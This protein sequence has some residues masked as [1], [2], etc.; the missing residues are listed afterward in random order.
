MIGELPDTDQL[1]GAVM[2][3]ATVASR[4]Q[5]HPAEVLKHLFKQHEGNW[6]SWWVGGNVDRSIPQMSCSTHSLLPAR[7]TTCSAGLWTRTPVFWRSRRYVAEYKGGANGRGKGKAPVGGLGKGPAIGC[8]GKR[9]STM[10]RGSLPSTS[11]V[12]HVSEYGNWK[13]RRGTCVSLA[14]LVA[15]LG[16]F[17]TA[18]KA[19]EYYNCCRVLASKRIHPW[20]VPV[21]QQAALGRFR[22]AVRYGHRC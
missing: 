11:D 10:E 1:S 8:V 16:E 6:W 21:C 17:Y 22:S 13:V 9:Q 5:Q 2:D 4:W 15:K 20:T 19:Y 3:P 12:L 18:A 14:T 7:N